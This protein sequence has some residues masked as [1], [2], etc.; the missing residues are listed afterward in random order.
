MVTYTINPSDD[1]QD[2]VYL[3]P[4]CLSADLEANNMEIGSEVCSI[5][6]GE[7]C[8]GMEKISPAQ[9]H[10]IFRVLAMADNPS[11]LDVMVQAIQ[12]CMEN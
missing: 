2:V 6:C 8:E 1:V 11:D 7:G 4:Q 9:T 12:V 3:L 10:A 5:S